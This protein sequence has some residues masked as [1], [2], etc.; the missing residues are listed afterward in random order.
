MPVIIP[1]VEVVTRNLRFDDNN[2]FATLVGPF[3]QNLA[4]L[5]QHTG[6]ILKSRGNDLL[7]GG[8]PEAI[9]LVIMALH[10]LYEQTRH[11]EALTEIDIDMA[12]RLPQKTPLSSINPQ[13][14]RQS[15][16]EHHKPRTGNGKSK[17]TDPSTNQGADQGIETRRKRVLPQTEGQKVFIE[18]LRHH[19]LTF[20]IGPAGT[21]KTYLATAMAVSSLM[22]GS[23]DRIILSRP[24]VEAG[25]RL[26]FL[27]GD[28]REKV[29]PYLRPLY[30]ALHDMMPGDQVQRKLE[31]GEIEIAPLA[32]MRGRTLARCFVILDEAQNCSPLQMKMFL[33]RLGEGARMT[34][35]G[36]LSQVDLPRGVPSGLS[37]AV[38]RLGSI[39]E[40]AI[41]RFREQ[42][43]VRHSLVSRIVRAYADYDA[44]MS[45]STTAQRDKGN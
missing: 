28:L 6:T 39:P 36:D 42:D 12:V 8:E 3:N 10:Q 34:V 15:D 38:E 25:E 29:D 33:T 5:E 41:H 32:F 1:T 13:N 35:T 18:K 30:D 2:R 17:K 14:H 9:N 11:Q 43:V 44:P 21:G 24:A 40:I 16:A 20:G 31:N 26:G 19:I 45:G 22:Q 4:R 7:I 27:P 37:E 23:V